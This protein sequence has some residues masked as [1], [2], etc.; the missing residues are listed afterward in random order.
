MIH[1][2]IDNSENTWAACTSPYHHKKIG[3]RALATSAA[4]DE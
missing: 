2:R 4:N 1:N 3:V